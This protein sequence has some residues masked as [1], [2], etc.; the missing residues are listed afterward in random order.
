MSTLGTDFQTDEAEAREWWVRWY[1]PTM[2]GD[3]AELREA[4]ILAGPRRAG[5][6]WPM[7]VFRGR[8][9]RESLVRGAKR[10]PGAR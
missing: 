8:A 5:E 6:S 4:L 3:Y 9:V 10:D 7:V 2:G 1:G